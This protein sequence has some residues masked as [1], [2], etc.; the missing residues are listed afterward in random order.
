MKTSCP[1]GCGKKFISSEHAERHADA[2]HADW[3]IPKS[4]GW[5]TPYGFIDFGEK[6]TFEEACAIAKKLQH[7]FARPS[8]IP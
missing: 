1:A 5:T 2:V 7:R 3:R 8:S 4:K 6:V